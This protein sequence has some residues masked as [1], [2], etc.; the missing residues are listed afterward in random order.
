MADP[1]DTSDPS[2]TADTGDPA[3]AGETADASDSAGA[4]KTADAGDPADAGETADTGDPTVDADRGGDPP[5][6][7]ERPTAGQ[8]TG[9]QRSAYMAEVDRRLWQATWQVRFRVGAIQL[10]WVIVTIAGA[11][12]ALVEAFDWPRWVAALLGFV[13]VVFQGFERIFGRTTEGSRS[14][15]VLRRDLGREKRLYLTGEGRYKDDA[16]PFSSFVGVAEA[17]I[18][19]NDDEEVA[20][21]AK[22]TGDR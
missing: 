12:V 17:I 1:S 14:V 19:R 3:D 9:E 5:D 7:A 20:Y 16:D 18:A 11:A 13:V 2:E 21:N 22:M 10:S 15:D 6:D 8:A 4:G